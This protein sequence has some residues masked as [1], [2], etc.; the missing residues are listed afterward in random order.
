VNR[1]EYTRGFYTSTT[2]VAA[3]WIAGLWLRYEAVALWWRSQ[4]PGFDDENS[5]GHRFQ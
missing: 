5:K 2:D 1:A 4:G 3:G